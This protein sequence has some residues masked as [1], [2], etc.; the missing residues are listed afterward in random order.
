MSTNPSDLPPIVGD[1]LVAPRPVVTPKQAMEAIGD[2][3][4]MM[5]KTHSFFRDYEREI[6]RRMPI[7]MTVVESVK[8]DLNNLQTMWFNLK[9]IRDRLIVH[10]YY[11][12]HPQEGQE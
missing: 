1:V 3:N 12:E 11:L 4:R 6:Y 8:A 5:D 10:L 7:Q 9:A 2:M